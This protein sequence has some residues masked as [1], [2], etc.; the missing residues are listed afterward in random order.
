MLLH[1]V[2]PIQNNI[3]VELDATAPL[4]AF[5]GS[6]PVHAVGA[7]Y[8]APAMRAIVFTDVCGSVAQ[9]QELGDEGHL[10]VVD[11][12]GVVDY[13]PFLTSAPA[14]GCPTPMPSRKRPG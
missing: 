6:I 3:R 11:A 5:F 1:P 10:A 7:A 12:D 8:T 13:T 4:N 2:P 14:P 9:T